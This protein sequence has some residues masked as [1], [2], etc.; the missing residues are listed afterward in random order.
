MRIF[1]PAGVFVLICALYSGYWLWAS[2]R[3][4]DLVTDWA[5][6]QRAAGNSVSWSSLDV[7]GYPFRLE[8]H[9]GDPRIE[10][11][12]WAWRG[13][14][15]VLHM[16][17]YSFS[18]YIGTFQGTHAVRLG[19]SDAARPMVFEGEAA[20]ARTSVVL[21]DEG[22]VRISV[23]L[24]GLAARQMDGASGKTLTR[25]AA[26]RL[27][28]HLRQWFSPGEN[29]ERQG[30]L[31]VAFQAEKADWPAHGLEGLGSVIDLA[32]GQL[33][34]SELPLPSGKTQL[35]FADYLRAW[36]SNGGRARLEGLDL[37]WDDIDLSASGRM[38]LDGRGRPDGAIDTRIGGHA[39]ILDVLRSNRVMDGK[40]AELVENALAA[41]NMVSRGKDGRLRLP[42]KLK[43]GAVYLGPVKLSRLEPVY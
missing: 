16:M 8:A 30:Q 11:R 18:H 33:L 24:K 34:F 36:E 35:V 13:D 37:R 4:E 41:L 6:E 23:D 9:V 43:K 28:L 22:A 27:Q 2:D 40:Q 39:A 42:V 21:E 17:P 29:G 15:F 32:R 14:K 10:S 26:E 25:I 7:R 20:Q 12:D 38:A 3:M 5:Q 1:L 19:L 31:A